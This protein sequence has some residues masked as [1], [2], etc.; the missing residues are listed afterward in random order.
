M[1]YIIDTISLYYLVLQNHF[2]WFLVL[3]YFYPTEAIH[4]SKKVGV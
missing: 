4:Q 3:V 1:S 2:G